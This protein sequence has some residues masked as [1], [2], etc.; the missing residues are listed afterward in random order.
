VARYAAELDAALVRRGVDVRRYALGRATRPLPPDTRHVSVP[1]RA[2]HAC[3]RHGEIPRI[4]WLTPGADVGHTL[5]LVAPPSRR[6]SVATVHDLDAIAFPQFHPARAVMTQR[7]QLASLRRA[8]VVIVDSRATLGPLADAGIPESRVIVAPLGRTRLPEA[9]AVILPGG[10]PY[11]LSVGSL[12]W[13]KAHDVLVRAMSDER[14]ASAALVLAGPDGVGADRIR[15]AA[16]AL[17]RR[18][19]FEG[20][21]DDARLAGLYAGASAF[22]LASRAEGFGL[23]VLEAM[24]GGIPVVV[25][26]SPALADLVGDAGVV[27]PIDDV[28]ALA[29]ALVSILADPTVAARLRA[30]GPVRA[31]GFTWEAC[32]AATASAYER[33]LGGHVR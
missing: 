19:V 15:E 4:E 10:Q 29:D 24:A 31:A 14:L 20:P 21:V 23:P 22:V 28:T 8:D 25:S 26:A 1:L 3:W 7:A 30:A 6:P 33:A 12:G 27:V 2:L 5:D 17:E 9:P 32:A 16:R 11:V 13:R 18:V